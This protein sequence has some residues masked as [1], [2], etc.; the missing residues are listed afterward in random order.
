[1]TTRPLIPL[2]I[3]S[4]ATAAW[5]RDQRSVPGGRGM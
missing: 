4:V 3:L 5:C 2:V 1:M